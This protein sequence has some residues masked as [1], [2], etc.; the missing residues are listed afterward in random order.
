MERDADLDTALRLFEEGL[1]AWRRVFDEYPDLLDDDTTV[2]DMKDIIESYRRLL[3]LRDQPFPK[4]F[5]LQD[6]LDANLE[7]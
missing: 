6:V 5:I 1:Q 3:H 7:N 4:D 2:D